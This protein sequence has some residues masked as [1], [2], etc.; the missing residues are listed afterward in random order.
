MPILLPDGTVVSG[1]HDGIYCYGESPP[2]VPF[3][4]AKKSLLKL[5]CDFHRESPLRNQPDTRAA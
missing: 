4:E 2:D 1:Y 5:V 3:D